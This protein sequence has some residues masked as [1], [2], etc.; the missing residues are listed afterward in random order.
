MERIQEIA[1]AVKSA[2]AAAPAPEG[3]ARGAGRNAFEVTNLNVWYGLK[4][5]VQDV[6]MNIPE[7]TITAIIGP[8]G[9]GKSTFLRCLNRMHEL[10]PK[11]RMSGSIRFFGQ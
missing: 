2:G 5:A 1:P 9:C 8:S 3:A 4:H 7:R 11:A 6:T 10:V